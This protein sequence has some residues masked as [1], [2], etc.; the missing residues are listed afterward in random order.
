MGGLRFGADGT[1]T[2][3]TGTFNYGQGHATAFAQVLVDKLGVPFERIRLIQGDSDE[4]IAGGGSGGSRSI[5]ASGSAILAAGDQVIEKGR[6]LAGHF[7]EAASADVEFGQ[8]EFRIAGTDRAIGIMELAERTRAAEGLPEGLPENLDV[9]LVADAVPS[10]FPNGCHICEVDVD[11]ETGAVEVAAYTVVDDF[12]TLVNP[13]LVEG[14]VHGGVV[15][16]IGQALMERTAHDRDGQ[17]LTGSFMDY[18]VP[19]ADQVP[20]LAFATHEVPATT[21]PLGVKGCG[22]AGVTGALPAVMNALADAFAQAGATP[23]DMPATPE[24]VWRALRQAGT[25]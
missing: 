18:A 19:R 25:A 22:E 13:L 6:E 2:I 5:M 20:D 7:L 23:V 16:G 15:Q 11:P 14:Q 21:N 24:K 1:V 10:T 17:P 9:E 3:V 12:G 4:L 8:G